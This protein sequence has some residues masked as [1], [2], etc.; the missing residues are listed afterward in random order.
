LPHNIDVR[1]YN[2]AMP[3]IVADHEVE[4]S[5]I[6]AQGPGGQHVNK[7]STAIQLRFNVAASGLPEAVKT[8][9]LALSD[10]RLSDEGVVV[11]KSQGSRSQEANKAEALA[12]LQELI[13]K[14]EHVP[15]ARRPTKPTYGSK[16]RRL[17]AKAQRAEVKSGRGKVVR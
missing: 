10:R 13:A 8:R 16:Q 11:I 2:R 17:T 9:L 12:R 6:R 3:Y 7:A 14:A 15:R 4:F 1:Q 5:A